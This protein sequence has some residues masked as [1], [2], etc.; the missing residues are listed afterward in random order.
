[1]SS[2]ILCVKSGFVEVWIVGA[3]DMIIKFHVIPL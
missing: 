2:D 3:Y 1:M